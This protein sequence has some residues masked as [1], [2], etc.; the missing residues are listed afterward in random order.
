M[1]NLSFPEK[2]SSLLDR[3]GRVPSGRSFKKIK[4]GGIPPTYVPARN[5]IFLSFATAFAESVKAK[6]IFIGA[7]TQDYSGYP[8]CGKEFFDIFKKVISAGTK[9]GKYIKISAP[10]VNKK[11]KE[12]VKKAFRLGVPLKFTWSCYEGKKRPCGACDSCRFRKKAF[13]E[14]GIKDPYYAAS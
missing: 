6:A 10:F 13:K 7:H 9:Y 1:I 2:A 12:I 4:T 8:D 3:K 5:L 14:L 11:K